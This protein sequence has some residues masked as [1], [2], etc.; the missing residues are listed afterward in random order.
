MSSS[1]LVSFLG[2]LAAST[3][4]IFSACRAIHHEDRR[5]WAEIEGCGLAAFWSADAVAMETVKPSN[6]E[7]MRFMLRRLYRPH[8]PVQDREV[9]IG[10]DG[11]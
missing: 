7:V 4:A 6:R 3:S 2:S 9:L 10:R 8:R 11:A 5:T 1:I